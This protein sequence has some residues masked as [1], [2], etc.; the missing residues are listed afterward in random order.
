MARLNLGKE[1]KGFI[2]EAVKGHTKL[3]TK[4]PRNVCLHL[5]LG[6]IIHKTSIGEMITE[7]VCYYYDIPVEKK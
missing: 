3:T 1:L 7:A 2:S 5:K 4:L 6:S